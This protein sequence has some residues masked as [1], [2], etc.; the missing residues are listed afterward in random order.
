MTT[1]NNEVQAPEDEFAAAFAESVAPEGTPPADVAPVTNGEDG[2]AAEAEGEMGDGGAA[3]TDGGESEPAATEAEGDGAAE[4]SGESNFAQELAK[5]RQE[6]AKPAEPPAPAPA[7][8]PE[9]P[10]AETPTGF[11]LTEDEQ[12]FLTEYEK[13][14]PEISRA[15]ALKRRKDLY[16]AV[17]Y[18]FAQV[19][20][21]ISPLVDHYKTSEY[22]SHEAA[23][24]SVHEDYDTVRPQVI[25]WVGTQ[26]GTRGKVFSEIVKGGTAEEIAD[27]VTIWKEATGKAKPQ[28]TQGSGSPSAPA[29]PPAKAK[30]AAQKLSVVSSKRTQVPAVTDA[31]DYDGAWAE[32][33]GKS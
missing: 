10:A 2:N 3:A 16:E 7:A 9:V 18:V 21:A 22:D 15:E 20:Q 17:Q 5:L 11:A 33:T 30:Q 28:V 25:D 29:E 8:E 12:K 24:K 13:D 26:T 6:I 27:L 1:E 14:W 31:N 19:S 32:A 23:I 4:S